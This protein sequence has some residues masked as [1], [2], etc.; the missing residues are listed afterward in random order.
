MSGRSQRFLG[1][2]S[3]VG[4]FKMCLAQEHNTMTPVGIEPRTSRFGVR[5]STTALPTCIFCLYF[6]DIQPPVMTNCP[7]NIQMN[8]TQRTLTVAWQEP[9]FTDPFDETIDIMS[10]YPM[11]EFN[12]NWGV[13]TVQYVATKPNNGLSTEC[14]FNINVRRKSN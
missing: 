3:T 14:V 9:D 6:I 8:A 13:Y 4:S 10:N 7:H 2:T 11:S 5:R 1:L 12:F